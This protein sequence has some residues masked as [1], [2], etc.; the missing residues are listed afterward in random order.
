MGCLN[1]SEEKKTDGLF[2][3]IDETQEV[4]SVDFEY[5]PGIEKNIVAEG[6]TELGKRHFYDQDSNIDPE[7]MAEC[8]RA[9]I[10]SLAGDKIRQTAVFKQIPLSEAADLFALSFRV[11]ET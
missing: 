6:H 1:V 4:S 9:A 8:Y 11:G 7:M 5:I 10:I 2:T 3:W